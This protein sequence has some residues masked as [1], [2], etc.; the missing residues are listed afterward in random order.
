MDMSPKC[1]LC[2]LAKESVCLHFSILIMHPP[3]LARVSPIGSLCLMDSYMCNGMRAGKVC[4][5][6][7]TKRSLNTSRSFPKCSAYL[8]RRICTTVRL[9]TQSIMF[10]NF[11]IYSLRTI[12]KHQQ[13]AP[14]ILLSQTDSKSVNHFLKIARSAPHSPWFYTAK[15]VPEHSSV[16]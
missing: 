1:V 13:R 14:C 3:C 7:K 12:R 6:T 16:A 11:T 9:T 2:I 10:V 5:Q 8:R 4:Q 15:L